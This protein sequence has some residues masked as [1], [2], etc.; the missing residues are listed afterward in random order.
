V[1][2]PFDSLWI[3]NSDDRVVDS[4]QDNTS[5]IIDNRGNRERKGKVSSRFYLKYS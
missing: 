3:N 5:D 1:L 4:E 2:G